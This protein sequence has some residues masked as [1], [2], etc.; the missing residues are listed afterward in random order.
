[1]AMSV[2]RKFVVSL[3]LLGFFVYMVGCG[4]AKRNAQVTPQ[5]KASEWKPKVR[6]LANNMEEYNVYAAGITISRPWAIGFVPKN[7]TRRLTGTP[8]QWYKVEN[9]KTLDDLIGWMESHP[10]A[11]PRLMSV[12]G[13]E[14]ERAFFG[15]IYSPIGQISTR[16]MDDNTIFV[17][18]PDPSM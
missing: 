14:P 12:L 8:D 11:V 18:V 6:E 16:V 5:L 1:M 13:P 3:I 4:A 15:Y 2:Q 7:S 9:K 17:F 10:G